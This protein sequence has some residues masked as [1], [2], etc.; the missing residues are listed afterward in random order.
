MTKLD[1]DAARE[2]R[3]KHEKYLL[4]AVANFYQEPI[5]LDEQCIIT[6]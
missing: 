5:V 3:E 2:A 4:P 6:G 1:T